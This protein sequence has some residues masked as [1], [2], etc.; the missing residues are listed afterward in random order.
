[1]KDVKFDECL[2]GEERVEV[3]WGRLLTNRPA[4]ILHL[5]LCPVITSIFHT[6]NSVT[7]A[8]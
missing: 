2:G 1:M 7:L 5:A 8:P 6:V 4:S 3:W